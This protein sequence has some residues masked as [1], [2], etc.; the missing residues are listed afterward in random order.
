MQVIGACGLS[1]SGCKAYMA[2]QANSLEKL[3]ELAK[4][5]GKPENPYTVEDM[6]CNGCM[7]D[8]VY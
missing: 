2:T 4:A 5:W 6:R 8:R 3:A 7:S 1:C